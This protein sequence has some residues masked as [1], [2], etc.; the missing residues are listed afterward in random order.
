MDKPSTYLKIVLVSALT[1]TAVLIFGVLSFNEDF[2][3]YTIDSGNALLVIPFICVVLLIGAFLSGGMS[4]F[5]SRSSIRSKL[6]ERENE[7]IQ[8][9]VNGMKNQEIANAL[10]VEI[11]TIKTHINNIYSKLG[12]KNRNE[13]I[14]LIRETSE[15]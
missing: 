3:V 4:I 14:K 9:I 2:G 12:I 11:S 15:G 13:L 7:I 1:V 5:K 6:T 10:F 8:M